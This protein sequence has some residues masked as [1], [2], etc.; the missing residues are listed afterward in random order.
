MALRARSFLRGLRALRV[1]TLFSVIVTSFAVVSLAAQSV[2]PAGP[3]GPP[4]AAQGPPRPGT[5]IVTGR[6]LAGDDSTPVAAA[7]VSLSGGPLARFD[8]L[9]LLT[10]A[11]GR[12]FFTGVSAGTY[13]ITVTKPGWMPGAFGRSRPSGVSS[14]LVIADNARIP[15]IDVRLWRYGVL[16][17]RIV[18]QS[19][20]PMIGA[21]VRAF[22]VTYGGGIEQY[23]FI[24][25]VRTDDRGLYR[26]TSLEPGEYIVGVPATVTSEPSGMSGVIRSQTETPRAY[27]Q[28]MTG[29]GSVAMTLD[30]S[31]GYAGTDRWGISSTLAIPA[32][33]PAVGPWLTYPTTFAPGTSTRAGMSRVRVT[34]GREAP[35]VD[36]V[37]R[38]TPTFR[39]SGTVTGQDGPAAYHAVHL[40]SAEF[41]DAPLVDQSTAVT[42]GS[43]AFTFFGVPAGQYV[44]RV[45]RTPAGPN[46]RLGVA[47]MGNGTIQFVSTGPAGPGGPGSPPPVPTELLWHATQPVIVSDRDLSNVA[48][49]LRAGPRVSGRLQFDG[50]TAV[51]SQEAMQRVQIT[52]EPA[53]GRLNT[54]VMPALATA[55]GGF[56][57][58]SMWPGKYLIRVSSAPSGWTLATAM[59]QGRDASEHAID[60][61]TDVD[62]VV[63]TFTDKPATISGA[64][65]I[66]QAMSALGAPVVILFPAERDRWVNYGRSSRR[67]R[68]ASVSKSGSFTMPAPP[69]GEYRLIAIPDSAAADWQNPAFLARLDAMA[70]RIQVRNGQSVTQTL[71]LQ[72]VQ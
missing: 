34:S 3:G 66:D 51:P 35:A 68:A 1:S 12:F 42:D 72:R 54:N 49:A 11:Q 18:D 14:S 59:V 7:T 70:E 33:P 48:I 38:L 30:R 43:G 8:A 24:T 21:D 40:I 6:V 22:R 17:G 5:A 29:V 20:E 45:V 50:T 32:S 57:T 69:E 67:V 36:I 15:D 53:D 39:V 56:T 27:L 65:Q 63:L 13:E 28:T 62:D 37:M 10:D 44:A 4:G 23:T 41:A 61:A 64:V 47:S 9:R 46:M 2:L 31:E 60:L 71:R 19:G 58:P 55:V 16:G 26:F 52:L 25:R